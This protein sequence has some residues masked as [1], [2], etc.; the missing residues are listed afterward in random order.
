L[1]S[2]PAAARSDKVRAAKK[3]FQTAMLMPV[4]RKT[5]N[6]SNRFKNFP[7]R[8]SILKIDHKIN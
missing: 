8:Y 6:F 4:L 2:D 7:N 1:V 3:P 5:R